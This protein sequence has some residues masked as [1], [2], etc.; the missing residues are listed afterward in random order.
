MILYVLFSS[1]LV[2]WLSLF[3]ML[4]AAAFA[5]KQRMGWLDSITDMNWNKLQVI[6]EAGVLQSLGSQRVEHNLV[7][8]QQ[9]Y[10][11]V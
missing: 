7:T 1:V 10:E 8:E 2:S 3:H 11:A 5:T 9:Q 6:E 4:T